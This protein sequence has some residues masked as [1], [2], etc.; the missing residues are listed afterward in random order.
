MGVFL[1]W[2][3]GFVEFLACLKFFQLLDGVIEHVL[4]LSFELFFLGKEC[5][6][7]VLSAISH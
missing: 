3:T 7:I 5:F 1:C 6:D 2:E 4:E